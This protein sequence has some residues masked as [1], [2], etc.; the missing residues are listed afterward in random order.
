M[1]NYNEH[2]RQYLN[3]EIS[4]KSNVW[5]YAPGA[6]FGIALQK[7]VGEYY[8]S[9]N[10][11]FDIARVDINTNPNCLDPDVVINY[12]NG[13]IVGIEVKSC[14][15]GALSGVTICNSPH[16]INDKCAI[17][18]NYTFINE[19]LSVTA[20]IITQ[21]FRLITINKTGKYVGCLSSTRDTGK[22]IKGR[23]YN[24]FISSSD[25]NDYTLKELTE[26]AL[27]RKTILYYS[28]SK[29]VDAEYN[30]TDAEVIQALNDLRNR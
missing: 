9:N 17:L 6:N 23:N 28:A 7:L 11:Y 4:K 2:I 24:E 3:T 22:K 14:K 26:P 21:I 29:L 19:V 27:I 13:T 5:K 20:V 12:N 10:K 1:R 8:K 15:D 16:L 18:I 30:F 25:E